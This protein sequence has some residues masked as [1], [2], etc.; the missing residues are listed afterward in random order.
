MVGEGLVVAHFRLGYG[1]D[2]GGD[3]LQEGGDV[4]RDC[5]NVSPPTITP[6]QETIEDLRCVI[7]ALPNRSG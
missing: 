6:P 7:S 1:V 4:P 2:E 5:Q 3:K